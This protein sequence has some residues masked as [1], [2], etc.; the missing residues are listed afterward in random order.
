MKKN[1]YL[2]HEKISGCGVYRAILPHRHCEPILRQDGITLDM[3]DLLNLE[4]DY[5][6]FIF[7]RVL[8]PQMLPAVYNLKKRGITIVWELD[9][10]LFEIPEWSP[11]SKQFRQI[12]LDNLRFCLDLADRLI[13]S[14]DELKAQLGYEDKTTVL[15]NLI[16]P[17]D[18]P[19][20]APRDKPTEWDPIRILWA[21]SNTHAA[22]IEL[23]AS[24]L[25]TFLEEEPLARAIFVGMV[26]KLLANHKQVV[27]LPMVPVECY[28][29]L[30]QLTRA[31]IALCPLVDH[32]FNR[33]KSCIKWLEYSQNRAAVIASDVGPYRD[34]IQDKVNGL[35]VK[36]APGVWLNALRDLTRDWEFS[37]QLGN[38]AYFDILGRHTWQADDK[39]NLWL[40]FFREL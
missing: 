15:P 35:L 38:Q 30:I 34:C 37:R 18:Y 27:F 11:A 26:P 39:R 17:S 7:H 23:V 9:D 22:D 3:P 14:T 6:A 5:D 13:V 33:A 19:Y 20:L 10:N 24:D 21:G 2:N 25:L 12:D 4:T 8:H 1:V 36:N 32:P 40:N 28:P 16:D 31:H 29:A